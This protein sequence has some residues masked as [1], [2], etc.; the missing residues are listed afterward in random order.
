[1]SYWIDFNAQQSSP[2]MFLVGDRNLKINGKTLPNGSY[3]IATQTT[4]HWGN[5][6]H[7]QGGNVGR[8]DGS[9]YQTSQRLLLETRLQQQI[10]TNWFGIP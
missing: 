4:L 1:L 8:A 2:N 10:P 3:Q 7:N 6:I 5:L 9:V